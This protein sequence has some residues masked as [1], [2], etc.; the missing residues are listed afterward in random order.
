[1]EERT[2]CEIIEKFDLFKSIYK[3]VKYHIKEDF[4]KRQDEYDLYNLVG[5]TEDEVIYFH[6]LYGIIKKKPVNCVLKSLSIKNMC[7]YDDWQDNYQV[8]FVFP[9][10]QVVI[11]VYI[12]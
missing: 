10:G 5:E 11:N 1:M 7:T 6:D 3:C 8:K 4:T 2:V 12:D 9:D